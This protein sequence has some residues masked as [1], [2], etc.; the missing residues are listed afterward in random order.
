MTTV[1]PPKSA[2]QPGRKLEQ[3]PHWTFWRAFP[4]MYKLRKMSVNKQNPDFVNIWMVGCVQVKSAYTD[5]LYA[6]FNE[7]FLRYLLQP[8]GQD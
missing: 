3:R 8:I 2:C 7:V 1:C 5:E 6:C 4:Q